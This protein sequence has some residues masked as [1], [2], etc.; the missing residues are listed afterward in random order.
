MND[1][2]NGNTAVCVD[3]LPVDNI[4]DGQSPDSVVD[5]TNST[6]LMELDPIVA[7]V[8]PA[9]L[10]LSHLSVDIVVHIA[11]FLAQCDVVS[12]ARCNALFRLRLSLSTDGVNGQR[13]RG[14]LCLCDCSSPFYFARQ[15]TENTMCVCCFFLSR[16][17]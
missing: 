11:S 14:I 6:D 15:S 16:L 10:C 12:L 5:V 9:S 3:C 8:T 13:S 7:D 17:C 2:L 1:G 4:P